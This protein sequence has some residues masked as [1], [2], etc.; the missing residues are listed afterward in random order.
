[1][2]KRQV[3]DRMSSSHPLRPTI[4]YPLTIFFHKNPKLL[5]IGTY[6]TTLDEFS[7]QL[8]AVINAYKEWID[9]GGLREK[10]AGFLLSLMMGE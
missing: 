2:Y 1:M 10:L 4:Q 8:D 9:V 6:W 5:K 7:K 3:D